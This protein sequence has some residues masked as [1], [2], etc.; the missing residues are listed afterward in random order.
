MASAVAAVAL[1]G[2][3]FAAAGSAAFGLGLAALLFNKARTLMERPLASIKGLSLE[4][5]FRIFFLQVLP[6]VVIFLSSSQSNFQFCFASIIDKYT[7]RNNCKSFFRRL[8]LEFDQ[9][10]F[11]KEQ[12]AI[13]DG[14]VVVTARHAVGR[15]VELPNEKFVIKKNTKSLGQGHL[16]FSDGL[17]LGSF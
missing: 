12:L 2:L 8:S 15:N 10:F 9:L 14:F 11:L 17:D 13:T 6:F 1:T 5:P 16:S 7:N 3:L 4:L